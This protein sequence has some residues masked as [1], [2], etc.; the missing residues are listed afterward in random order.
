MTVIKI[1]FY[2]NT[3]RPISTKSTHNTYKL[4]LKIVLMSSGIV[5]V[6]KTAL[7]MQVNKNCPIHEIFLQLL[8]SFSQKKS[9]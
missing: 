5:W 4:P 8:F 2:H 1:K 7:K 3:K 9:I 6:Q